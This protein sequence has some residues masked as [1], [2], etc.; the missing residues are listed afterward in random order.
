M[1][2]TLKKPAR[3]KA[4]LNFNYPR[5]PRRE[6]SSQPSSNEAGKKEKAAGPAQKLTET[7]EAGKPQ[8]T[9]TSEEEYPLRQLR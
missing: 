5:P 8:R 9:K 2:G 1:N 7:G 3:T 6:M 4:H